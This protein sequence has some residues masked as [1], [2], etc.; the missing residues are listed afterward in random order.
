M[1]DQKLILAKQEDMLEELTETL[2]SELQMIVKAV[3]GSTSPELSAAIKSL[4]K[5][6][7]AIKADVKIDTTGIEAAIKTIKLSSGNDKSLELIASRLDNYVDNIVSL[8]DEMKSLSPLLKELTEIM[9]KDVKI[10]IER[11]GG[12]IKNMYLMRR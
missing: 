3:K 12:L 9:S 11:E 8:R 10:S 1:M 7:G 2:S 4:E 5:S 6:I